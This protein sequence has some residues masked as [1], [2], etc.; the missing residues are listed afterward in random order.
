M[1]QLNKISKIILNSIS[2][3]KEAIMT[4]IKTFTSIFNYQ[5]IKS[6]DIDDYLS[7][8]IS[9]FND[10]SGPYV[11]TIFFKPPE[12]AFFHVLDIIQSSL[13][14][15]IISD[16]TKKSP[17]LILSF[18]FTSN[19]SINNQL[20]L[21]EHNYQEVIENLQQSN[22]DNKIEEIIDKLSNNLTDKIINNYNTDLISISTI[23]ILVTIRSKYLYLKDFEA[24]LRKM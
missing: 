18:Q 1:K 19:I 23:T 14:R 20:R 7:L 21:F 10:G 24:H 15:K 16:I 12:N 3:F 4:S 17:N 6:V 9:T 22:H 13:F 8:K 2:L 11:Y 5:N